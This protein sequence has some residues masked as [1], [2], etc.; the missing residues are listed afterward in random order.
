MHR[1]CVKV[2][3]QQVRHEAE[4]LELWLTRMITSSMAPHLEWL[5]NTPSRS[6][7]NEDCLPAT[8]EQ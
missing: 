4:A 7:S 1:E 2:E 5:Q 6:H 3:M 8:L